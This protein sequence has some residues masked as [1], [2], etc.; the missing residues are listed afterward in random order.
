MDPIIDDDNF[1]SVVTNIQTNKSGAWA[2][3]FSHVHDGW[4]G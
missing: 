4:Y 3:S 2:M 1:C